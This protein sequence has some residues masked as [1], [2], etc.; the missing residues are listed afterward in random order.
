ML[1]SY[2][3]LAQGSI[4]MRRDGLRSPRFEGYLVDSS[5]SAN[6]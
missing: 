1:P 6:G 3:P 2:R 5:D 4:L